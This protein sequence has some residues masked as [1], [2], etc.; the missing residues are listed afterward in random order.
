MTIKIERTSDGDK[1]RD[2]KT[3]NLVGSIGQGK[4]NLPTVSQVDKDKT[5]LD[6]A[7]IGTSKSLYQEQ[8]ERLN[9]KQ[10]PLKFKNMK[11]L[12]SFIAKDMNWLPQDQ[13][14]RNWEWTEK[15]IQY[16]FNTWLKYDGDIYNYSTGFEEI[17]SPDPAFRYEEN[18]N[19]ALKSPAKTRALRKLGYEHYLAQPLPVFVFGT[20]RPGQGNF[21][22][23]RREG[24]IETISEAKIYGVAMV[25]PQG[26]GFPRSI[27]TNDDRFNMMGDVI[28]LSK[29]S[30]GA[31]TRSSLDRLE[32]FNSDRPS[33]SMYKRVAREVQ[34]KNANGEE[35]KIQAWIYI[36]PN[37]GSFK[38]ED[39][40]VEGD[41][42]NS[43]MSHY[44]P[45]R[46][47]HDLIPTNWLQRQRLI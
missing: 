3:G 47:E 21:N 11:E 31:H 40:L 4:D 20:L 9:L 35:E 10:N 38:P 25:I 22:L 16:K 42:F 2:T 6:S 26:A 36:T 12:N 43:D 45:E 7:K 34:I 39:I 44:R 28:T 37:M 8:H 23:F 19:L 33:Q 14:T 46:R 17:S 1:L 15:D 5:N 29:D 13:Y 27:E 24:S 30:L 18:T 41:W 32:G